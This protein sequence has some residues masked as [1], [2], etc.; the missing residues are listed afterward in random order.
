MFII[1]F[2]RSC[3]I[4]ASGGA[5]PR[6]ISCSS[7]IFKSQ[8][9]SGLRGERWEKVGSWT[10]GEKRGRVSGVSRAPLPLL[11]QEDPVRC[12]KGRTW[13]ESNA[14]SSGISLRL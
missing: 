13:Y 10:Q 8:T 5:S 2:I 12:V 7:S 9:A 11:A 6:A 4:V 1:A 14:S 3:D